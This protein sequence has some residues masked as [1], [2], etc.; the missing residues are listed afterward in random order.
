VLVAAIGASVLSLIVYRLTGALP[1]AA[2]TR[3]LLGTAR[4][5]TDLV[6]EVDVTRD[7][8]RGPEDAAVTVV[9]YGDFECPWTGMVAPT[10]RELLADNADIRYVWR[11][12][13][14]HDVHPHAQ[15]AAEAAEAGAPS[16]RSGRCTTCS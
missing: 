7:H 3:A 2:R 16:E 8:V 14:L 12:L 11:H 13:P 6:P 1:D 4:Q 10:A 5:L 9:E 15:L